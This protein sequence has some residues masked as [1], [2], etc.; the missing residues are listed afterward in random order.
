MTT[1]IV[2]VNYKTPD[3]VCD[4]LDS[5]APEIS[6]QDIHVYIGDADSQD[7][8]VLTISDHIVA[9]GYNWADC[10]A[11]GRNG[12]F[13]YGNNAIVEACVLGDKDVD[14]VHFLNPDTYIHPGAVRDLIAF[15]EAHPDAGIVGSRLENPD[16]T[17]RAYAFRRPSVWREFFRGLRLGLTARLWPATVAKIDGLTEPTRVDWVSGASFAARRQMLDQIGLMDAGY[18]LYFEETDLMTRA[19]KAGYE[20]WHLPSSRVV[21]LAGQATG[22]RHGKD[23]VV[24]PL[25][26]IWLKSR[27]RY[28]RK[29]CGRIGVFAAN[30][31][32]LKGDT[33]YRLHRLLAR[34]PVQNPP[35]M[36]RS[37]LT[38][39]EDPR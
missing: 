31:M 29:H 9:R 21:H 34:K 33:L 38:T 17:P 1:A 13:A 16:G 23:T 7:G 2:I 3:L 39:R 6:G 24:E 35:K 5:L 4:C 27:A 14:Y 22:V 36:W 20:V 15:L 18:F 12:G 8:S 37:Y 10:F 32:F 25:S 19:R 28:F 26:P 11:I 30:M